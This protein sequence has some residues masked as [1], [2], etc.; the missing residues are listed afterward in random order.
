M[1]R[2]VHDD[3]PPFL[4]SWRRVY[5]AVALYLVVLITLFYLFGKAWS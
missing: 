5:T 2:A 1:K 3:P 4:G